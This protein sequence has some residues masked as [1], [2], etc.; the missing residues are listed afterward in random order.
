MYLFETYK[1]SHFMFKFF[2]FLNLLFGLIVTS[3]TLVVAL[4]AD[5]IEVIAKHPE[6]SKSAIYQINFIVS[7]Q[8]GLTLHE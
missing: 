5:T 4:P 6:I 2:L 7:N 1:K 3:S 8:Y